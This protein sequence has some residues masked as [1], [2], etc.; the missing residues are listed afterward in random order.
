M[1]STFLQFSLRQRI[2]VVV[3][4]CALVAGGIYSFRIISIDAFPDVT[5]VLVQVVTKVQ[6]LS[7]EEVERFV[8]FPIELQLMGAPGL[9]DVRSFSKVGLSM[10]TVVFRDDVDI[11]LARQVVLERVLEVQE[12]LPPGSVSQLVPNTTGLGEVYQFYLKGPHDDDPSSRVTQDELMERR[13]LLDWVIRPILKGLKDVVDVNSMGGFVKQ[14]QVMVEPGLLRKYELALHDVFDAVAKNNANAGGNILEKGAEKYIVRGLGLIKAV[15]DIENIVVKE[16]RGIPVYVRDVAEVQIGP[17]VRHGAAVVNGTREAVAGIVLMLRGGNAREVVQALKDKIDE[18]H[19]KKILPDGL[20]IVPFYDR[21]ELIHAA[22]DT[23]YKAMI[24]GIVLVV[25]VLFLFLGNVRSALVVTATLI[26][27]PLTTFIVMDQVGMTANLMSLGGLVIAIGMMVDGSVVVVENVYRLLSEHHGRDQDRMA[28]IIQAVKEVGQPVIFGILIIILVFLPILSLQGMEGKMFHPLA[29][30]IMIALLVSLIVSLTLS[31]VLCWF[32]LRRGSEEDTFIVRWSKKIYLP[33]LNWALEHRLIV[34]GLALLLLAGSLGL[35]PFL[36]GEFIPILNEAAITPQ[37]IRHPSI[38]LEKSIDI[39]K[40]MQ[41]AVMEFPEVR[42]VVSKIGR[43]ELGNDP[44]EPNASDPVVT[45]KPMDEWTTATTKPELDNAIRKRIEK[46]PGANYLLSQPIQQRV[47]ELVSG[48]RAEATVKVLGE[49]LGA[50]RKIAEDIQ[51]IMHKV[52]GVQ[53]VR[54]EQ[55][56]GQVYLTVDIDRG[57]IA[58]HGINVA[59]IRE[60][61][62]HGDRGRGGHARL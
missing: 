28:L 1:L 36:G 7:P 60:I 2:L 23:V 57:K 19:E 8:T 27:T 13:T 39:E 37:T 6:G 5:N 51:A 40:E 62:T 15:E 12:L 9:T 25:A 41:Q 45:L 38:S 32:S 43:S 42:Q 46:V 10:I 18:I 29:Y 31:P 33:A 17:A 53:D 56:F 16:V 58:R 48:V 49:D 4:A 47:D 22:L 30:S 61:I 35:F 52:R 20:R 11:Y 24:E 21:I 59:H 34:L 55:L 3:F 26:V 54:V 50:L 44:Q 14:Y